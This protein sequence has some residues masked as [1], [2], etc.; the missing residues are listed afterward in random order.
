MYPTV[1]PEDAELSP[2]QGVIVRGN[3]TILPTEVMP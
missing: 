3:P 2:Q 1:T